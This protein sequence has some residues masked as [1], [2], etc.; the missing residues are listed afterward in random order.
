MLR[1][2]IRQSA[3]ASADGVFG[4]IRIKMTKKELIDALSQYPDDKEVCVY[5]NHI[6]RSII[7]VDIDRV[8]DCI[9]L[10]DSNN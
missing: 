2:N 7:E 6:L 10:W 8:D 1:R 3:A 9:V 4:V 5:D